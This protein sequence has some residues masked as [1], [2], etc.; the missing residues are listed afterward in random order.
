MTHGRLHTKLWDSN[1]TEHS[2][3]RTRAH[4]TMIYSATRPPNEMCPYSSSQTCGASTCGQC[5]EPLEDA[6]CETQR[7]CEEKGCS[8]GW[9]SQACWQGKR[10]CERQSSRWLCC[11][12]C[13][14]RCVWFGRWPTCFAS[15]FASCIFATT[16]LSWATSTGCSTSTR[17]CTSNRHGTCTRF[18]FARVSQ[19]STPSWFSTRARRNLRT[20]QVH[21][22]WRLFRLPRQISTAPRWFHGPAGFNELHMFLV[23]PSEFLEFFVYDQAGTPSATSIIQMT[24]RR[25]GNATGWFAEVQYVG[26]SDPLFGQLLAQSLPPTGTGVLHVCSS[27]SSLCCTWVYWPEREVIHSDTVRRRSAASMT[28]VWVLPSMLASAVLQ[29]A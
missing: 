29:L 11:G 18:G 23:N 12:T 19:R 24:R 2:C 1:S 3:A 14:P 27:V 22:L 15:T 25:P 26:C 28:E 17:S 9:R 13:S 5:Y 4:V 6:S 20:V 8:Q 7:R 10:S 16:S 21:L